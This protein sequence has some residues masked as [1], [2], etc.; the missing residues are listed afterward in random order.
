MGDGIFP[1]LG[2]QASQEEA[3]GLAL[4]KLAVHTRT[5]IGEKV[6]EETVPPPAP[7]NDDDNSLEVEDDIVQDRIIDASWSVQ[8]RCCSEYIVPRVPPSLHPTVQ[9]FVLMDAVILRYVFVSEKMIGLVGW[10]AS[11]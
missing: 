5:F 8:T 2:I 6:E 1:C 3:S 7:P 10:F 9:Y 11:L 4:P